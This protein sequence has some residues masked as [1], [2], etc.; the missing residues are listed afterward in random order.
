MLV[1]IAGKITGDENY[2]AKFQRVE[3]DLRSRGFK[4]L[5]PTVMPDDLDYEDYF[6][7]CFA[8]IDIADRVIVIDGRTTSKG[9]R[10][11]MLYAKSKNKK[12][13]KYHERI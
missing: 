11:E 12:V 6:P 4:V 5:N 3:K 1:Y 2:K 9:V 7:I 8:M 13:E 10:R